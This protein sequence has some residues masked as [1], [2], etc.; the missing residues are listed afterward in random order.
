MP[1]SEGTVQPTACAGNCPEHPECAGMVVN[2]P[3]G[4]RWEVPH[5]GPAVPN[6]RCGRCGARYSWDGRR[7]TY[8]GDHDRPAPGM[9]VDDEPETGGS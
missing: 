6:A 5:A 1:G 2:Q 9:A 4:K 7:L 3:A 8:L